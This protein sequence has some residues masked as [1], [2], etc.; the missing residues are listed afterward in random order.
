L[1]GTVAVADLKG[2]AVQR[3]ERVLWVRD[4]TS[5]VLVEVPVT[6]GDGTLLFS[7]LDIRSHIDPTRSTY[8]P[9]ADKILWNMLAQH[10]SE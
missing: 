3:G 1:P 5:A 10:N 2:P 8:D 6:S 4:P 9:A 7:Q